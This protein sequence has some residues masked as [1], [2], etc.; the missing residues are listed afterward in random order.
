MLLNDAYDLMDLLLDKSDQP[1]FVTEEKDKFLEIAI[2]DFVEMNYQE[3]SINEESRRVMAPLIDWN[4]FSLTEAEIISG[5]YIYRGNYPALSLKY[6]DEGIPADPTSLATTTFTAS[7]NDE[8]GYFLFGNQYVLPRQHLYVLS[9]GVQ[10]YNKDDIIDLSTG[11]TYTG[12]TAADVVISPTVSAK[13]KS[14][15]DYYEH[16][17]TK[18]PFNKSDEDAP[19]WSYIENRI[20][21]ASSSGIRYINMQTITLP[22]LQRAFSAATYQNSTAPA[23]RV[24]TDHYQREIVKIA[25]GLMTKVDE[26]LI[27]PSS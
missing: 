21:F 9:I 20:T 3:M 10:F 1:Y 23:S 4:S 7:T 22:T 2:S 15:K 18:D 16:A 5:N 12:V 8:K 11:L 26:G 14:T 19:Y 17:Y 13:N 27:T 6:T 25:V 24:F